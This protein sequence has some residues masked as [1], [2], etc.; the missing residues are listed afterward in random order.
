MTQKSA[1]LIYFEAGALITLKKALYMQYSLSVYNSEVFNPIGVF[2]IKAAIHS[3]HQV[4]G[5][6]SGSSL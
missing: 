5:A 6:T 4:V 1:V 3:A 2:V